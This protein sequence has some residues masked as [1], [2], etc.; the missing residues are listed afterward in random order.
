LRHNYAFILWFYGRFDEAEA[1]LRGALR[2]RPSSGYSYSVLGQIASS[3]G[4]Y[5]TALKDLNECI[6]LAPAGPD[7]FLERFVVLW[8]LNR[9]SDAIKDLSRCIELNGFSAVHPRDSI[10]SN[11]G[12]NHETPSPTLSAV[13]QLLERR[14]AEGQFVS[15][16]DLARFY[17]LLGDKTHALDRLEQ[18]VEEHRVFTLSAKVQA[19]FKELRDE[20]RYHASLRRLHLEK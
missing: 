5:D 13:I 3:R 1:M 10:L 2:E 7:P 4:D 11:N 8:L 19:A 18:A 17:A 16:F 20:P 12:S 15:A 6:L 9:K 14:R